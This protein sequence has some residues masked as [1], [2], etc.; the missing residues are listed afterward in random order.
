MAFK[1]IYLFLAALGLLLPRL[2]SGC[3]EWGYSLGVVHGR[4][5]EEASLAAERRLQGFRLQCYGPRGLEHRLNS[6]G[7]WA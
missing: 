6:C 4:L 1:L 2:S 7:A 5:T 3:T